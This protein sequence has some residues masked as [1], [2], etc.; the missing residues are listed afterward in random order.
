MSCLGSG[1]TRAKSR[2]GLLE[3]QAWAEEEGEQ[4][5]GNSGVPGRKG[6]T[7]FVC[8]AG[9]SLAGG[10]LQSGKSTA[11]YHQRME[12]K[13]ARERAANADR[14]KFLIRVSAEMMSG[15]GAYEAEGAG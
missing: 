10:P 1:S 9:T 3:I 5:Y 12:D 2:Y 13:I 7:L 11:A 4:A 14:H 15:V 6:I 8:T